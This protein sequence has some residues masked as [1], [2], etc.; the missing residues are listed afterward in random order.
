MRALNSAPAQN[1]QRRAGGAALLSAIFAL[2]GLHRHVVPC[3]GMFVL[4]QVIDQIGL[5][6][7]VERNRLDIIKRIV[8]GHRMET[9]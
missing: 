6:L 2:R 5:C 9:R 1:R 3:K 7:A 8:T 4:D